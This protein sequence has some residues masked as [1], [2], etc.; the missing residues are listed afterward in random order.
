MSTR[1]SKIKAFDTFG[2]AL[3]LLEANDS[4]LYTWPRNRIALSHA[5]AE[6]IRD[7]IS[8]SDKKLSVDLCPVLSKSGKTLNPD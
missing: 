8:E 3:A 1:R 7:L 2:K 5:L 4:V 6:H